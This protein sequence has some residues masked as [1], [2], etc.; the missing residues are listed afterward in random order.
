MF[1][2][3]V[4]FFAVFIITLAMIAVS[5]A[6]VFRFPIDAFQ[7]QNIGTNIHA[8]PEANQALARIASLLNR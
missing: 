8:C 6:R 1:R 4:D 3:N 2:R 7:V 5:R